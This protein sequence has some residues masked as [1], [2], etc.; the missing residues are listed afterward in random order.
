MWH[1][2]ICLNA[3]LEYYYG[4]RVLWSVYHNISFLFKDACGNKPPCLNNAIASQDSQTKVINVCAI[5]DS[6]VNIATRVHVT[7]P[8]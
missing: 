7:C 3:S 6:R 8:Y 2:I 5:L 1:N 4:T